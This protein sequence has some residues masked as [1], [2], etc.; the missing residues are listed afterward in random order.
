MKIPYSHL[1]RFIPSKPPIDEISN[2]L[3]Q[4]GHEHE[5]DNGIFNFEFTPNRG[6]CLSLVGLARDL[7]VF[8]ETDLDLELYNNKIPEFKLNFVN[9]ATSACTNIA[10]LSIE[11]EG[12]IN[13]YKDYLENYFHDL[14]I[15]KTNFF[16]D[17]TNYAAYEMGQPTH[18]YDSNK[19]DKNKPI[20]L[21]IN[22]N[23]N[24]F[25]TLTRKN[26]NLNGGELVFLN[27][28]N[29]INLAGIM[30]GEATSCSKNTTNALIECAYFKPE[31]IIGKAVKYNI[32]SDASHKFERG[33]DP[34]CHDRVLRRIINII[35]DHTTIKK[36]EI[37]RYCSE[38]YQEKKLEIDIKKINKILGTIE[39][40]NNYIETLKRLNFVVDDMIKIP[41]FRN[42]ITHQNDLAEEFARAIGYDNILT[43]KIKVPYSKPQNISIE[44]ENQIKSLLVDNGFT[45]VI[46]A[47]FSNLGDLKNI[48][49][50]NPL[51][52]NKPFL[53]T[54]ILETLVDNLIF[55]EKRQQDSIK[56]FEISD[57][58]FLD[59]NNNI[60][61]ERRLSIIGSGR[62]AKNYKDFSKK[63]DLNY[64]NQ[65][66]K[67]IPGISSSAKIISRQNLSSKIKSEIVGVEFNILNLKEEISEYN[68]F[69][70]KKINDFVKYQPISEFPSTF[71]DISF[72][73]EDKAKIIELEKL[74]LGFTNQNLKESFIFDYYDN[75]KT[76]QTKIGVRFIFQAHD[77]TL[78]DNDVD[79]I[80]TKIIKLAFTIEG[81]IIPGIDR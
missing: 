74:M 65:I 9:N 64:F 27:D 18:S 2:F 13:K 52:T 15:S 46:N 14:K 51:D 45:E 58:Y 4:L 28:K 35:D 43:N 1:I 40:E 5:I 61:R 44:I 56:L 30:G 47:P 11:I 38:P 50:D 59:E 49:V 79:D 21:G 26:I 66:L 68:D 34:T 70:I 42:D 37:F 36:C 78:T 24:K 48:K 67:K 16:A 20:V 60:K 75:V 17:I 77:Q 7:N 76:N 54:S 80:M 8:Y 57:V 72:L 81:V 62:I 10:F 12:K 53:R 55:N 25:L 23:P 33:V 63:I 19:I 32:N 41:P 69:Y 39:S 31:T 71:R 3:F 29:I 22:K 6:D 73:I